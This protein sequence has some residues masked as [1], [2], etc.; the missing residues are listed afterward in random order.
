[1]EFELNISKS[2]QHG[3]SC[4]KHTRKT[5]ISRVVFFAR[6]SDVADFQLKIII[7][8]LESFVRGG[9]SNNLSGQWIP[10]WPCCPLNSTMYNFNDNIRDKMTTSSV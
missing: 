6:P 8:L 1:M 7:V 10:H 2:G 3:R 4:R 9:G 5:T